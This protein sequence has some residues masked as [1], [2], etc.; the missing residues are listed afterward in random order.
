MTER[1]AAYE[2]LLLCEKEKQFSNIALANG[3]KKYGFEGRERDFYTQL[4]Y[5]VIERQIT[6]DYLIQ[7][8]TGKSVKRLDKPVVNILRLAIY[9]IKF[10]DK[11]D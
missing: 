5:G 7:Q 2:T 8:Y 10:L 9:Q 6:L 1:L 3:I 4:V 11:I